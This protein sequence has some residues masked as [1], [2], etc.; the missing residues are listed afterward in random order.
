MRGI[1]LDA[2]LL[3]LLIAGLAGPHYVRRHKRLA[4][5]DGRDFELLQGLLARAATVVV[6]PHVLA[7]ASNLV[8]QIGE[9]A[10]SEMTA[11]LG[12]LTQGMVERHVPATSAMAGEAFLRLGLTDAALLAIDEAQLTLLTADTDLYLAASRAGRPV[13]NFN[14]VRSATR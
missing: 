3:V 8:R 9:P 1:I 6:T 4:A 11:T 2:Q 12:R 10:R 5:F 13:E 14:F 7:E